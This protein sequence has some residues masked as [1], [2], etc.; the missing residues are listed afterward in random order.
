MAI[1]A[2]GL[3]VYYCL[4]D[5]YSKV[6]KPSG[7]TTEIYGLIVMEG[8]VWGRGIRRTVLYLK[9]SE[10]LEVCYDLELKH[11]LNNFLWNWFSTNHFTM[12]SHSRG[13]AIAWAGGNRHTKCK[14]WGI[15]EAFTQISEKGLGGQVVCP[16]EGTAWSWE[17]EAKGAKEIPG[18]QR[19]QESKTSAEDS[20]RKWVGPA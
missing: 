13:I 9:V 20:F 11:P 18:S 3:G 16:W 15:M 10:G 12:L 1:T 14:T 8:R 6:H 17:T 5:C 2:V 4:T 7:K 19:C